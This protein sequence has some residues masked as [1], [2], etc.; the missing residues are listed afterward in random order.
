MRQFGMLE[1]IND[2]RLIQSGVC[3]ARRA[4]HTPVF[5]AKYVS[6]MIY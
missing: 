5:R 2:L 3:V 1:Q 6:P 4:T